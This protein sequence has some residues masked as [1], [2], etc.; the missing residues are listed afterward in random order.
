MI[1]NE[2]L[3]LTTP[4][5]REISWTR[6]FDAPPDL[7]F[8]ALTRPELLRRWLLGPDGW[9]MIVCEVD[10]RVGGAY[11]YVWSHAKH[12]QM[13]MGGIYREI[14]RPTRIVNTEVFDDVWYPGE[15]V[16][17]VVL[18]NQGGTTVLTGTM[19]YESREARDTALRTNMA[20]GMT[21]SYNRLAKL[22]PESKGGR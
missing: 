21:A 18:V 12:G 11:R 22:L 3:K 13:G 15:A 8:D 10:L 14:V 20:Y 9:S 7:V 16:G 19:L 17:T 1:V 2:S 5:D 6:V 4:T